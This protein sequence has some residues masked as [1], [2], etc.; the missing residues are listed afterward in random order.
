MTRTLDT[1]T[2]DAAAQYY[3]GAFILNRGKHDAAFVERMVHDFDFLDEHLYMVDAIREHM[4]KTSRD[5]F[6]A[7]VMKLKKDKPRSQKVFE[8]LLADKLAITPDGEHIEGKIGTVQIDARPIGLYDVELETPESVRHRKAN[9]IPKGKYRKTMMR[10]VP[11]YWPIYAGEGHER[12]RAGGGAAEPLPEGTPGLP[13]GALVFN[14]SAA[15]A[16]A[17]VDA[18]VDL[19]EGGTSNAVIECRSGA[20]PVD[21]DAATTGTL[22]A[23]LA[24]TDPAFGAAADQADG[25]AQA[26]AAAISDDVSVDATVTVGY[27]RVSTT[28]DG[29]TPVTSVLDGSAGVGTFDFVWNT[30]AFVS[31]ATASISAYLFNLSQGATAT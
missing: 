7:R 28:N 12:A 4:G 5:D 3:A 1:A 18:V 14:M 22:A 6:D 9:G 11:L 24:M 13:V 20:Q 27:N 23:S 19:L 30:V 17:A 29:L 25:T 10:R 2:L 15:A 16:V 31:G 21:P 8:K 26:A